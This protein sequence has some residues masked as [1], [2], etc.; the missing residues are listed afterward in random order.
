MMLAST[1]IIAV[2]IFLYLPA[3][4]IPLAGEGVMSAV[5]QVKKIE[6]SKVKMAVDITMVVVSVRYLLFR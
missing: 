5:S 4:V 2:G 1:V 3:D 6:F